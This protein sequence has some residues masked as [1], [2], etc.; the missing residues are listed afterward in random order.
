[1]SEK[2]TVRPSS[3]AGIALDSDVH[4]RILV[5]DDDVDLCDTLADL[6]VVAGCVVTT[7]HDGLQ[8]LRA[9][10]CSSPDVVLSDL[11]MPVCNGEELLRRARAHAS[12]VPRL[13]LMSGTAGLAESA[14]R[15]DVDYL[16]KPFDLSTLLD[17]LRRP[18]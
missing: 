3:A 10:A 5:V 2:V 1:M 12:P 4:L 8:A 6:L 11:E 15:L 18:P 9:I 13:I 14:Q 16:R 7:A 17:M